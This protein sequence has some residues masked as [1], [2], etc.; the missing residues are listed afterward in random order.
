[1]KQNIVYI[2][3]IVLIS[4]VFLTGCKT[5]QKVSTVEIGRTKE[6]KEFFD[7]MM[8]QAFQ[9]NTLTARLNVDLR[10]PGKELSSR[11]DLK[12]VR[13]SA[14]Q[15]SVQ[16][17]LG[18]E[19]LRIEFTPD[20]IKVVDRINK[21][22]VA[23]NYEK[24]RAET[25]VVFNFYNLQALFANRIFV[26]GEQN[27]PSSE[28]DRFTLKQEGSTAEI[29][30]KDAMNILYTFMADGEEK[31]LST[32]ITD[33]DKKYA[34]KWEYKDFRIA[35]GQPF[36]MLMDVNI[37]SDTGSP[38]GITMAFS[39]IQTNSALNFDFSIPNKYN[40]ITFG[41]ILKSLSNSKL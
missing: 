10:I 35:E 39:R 40:R 14:F 27:V 12:M 26:P 9:F 3:I 6:Q 29:Q 17:F 34:L 24:M 30:I 15:L 20:S 8:E 5:S 41:E 23:E 33:S 19:M 25:P 4:S 11:V 37:F 7:S 28:Y 32:Y 22:Y 2:G 21:R 31:L 18:I 36:P 38:G 16:P 13:D 1:M